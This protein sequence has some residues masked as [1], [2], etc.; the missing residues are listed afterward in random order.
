MSVTLAC[1]WWPHGDM[2]RFQKL[3]SQL[4]QV[5][6]SLVISV[7]GEVDP[8]D[9]DEV[10][11]LEAYKGVR[12]VI[13]PD[14]TQARHAAMRMSLDT[15]ASHIH[16]AD[17]DRLLRWVETRPIEWRQT[18]E[19]VQKAD[20]LI[21]GRTAAA[22]QTHPQALQKTEAII[23]LVFSH[24][25]GQP[26]D[27]CSGSKGFS[28]RAAEFLIANTS[29]GHWADA[30]WPMLLHRA[31]FKLE[32]IVV[33]GLDWETADRHQAQAADS[34]AQRRLADAHDQDARRWA[35]RVQVALDIVRE[36]LAAAQRK[37]GVE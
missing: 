6:E 13:P 21:I 31:G 35:L 36:G 2:P 12:V 11:T 9:L 29:P 25:L 23:N 24:L 22:F 20:C 26:V 17:M 28:R 33:D 32:A 19:A 7:S 34:D 5:Y 14:R 18:V 1:T 4:G 30:E 10:K 15:P 8:A 16:Y 27:L 3:Y 37:T